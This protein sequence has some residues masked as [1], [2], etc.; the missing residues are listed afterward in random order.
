[1]RI[2]HAL[3]LFVLVFL[4]GALHGETMQN[5]LAQ[6]R[7]G[8]E[9]VFDFHQ[10]ITVVGVTTTSEHTVQLRVTTATKDLLSREN[11]TTWLQW[12]RQGAPGALSDDTITLKTDR[13]AVVHGVNTQHVQWL[14]TLL[15]LELT[16]IPDSKRRRAGPPPSSE[17]IDLRPLFQP[18]IV[19]HGKPIETKTDAYSTQMPDDGTELASRTLI[20]YFPQSQS[21]VQPFPYWIES[22]SSSYH[23]SVID[24]ASSIP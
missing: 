16:K 1:M 7:P 13:A 8:D 24:S 23:V 21:A 22:P 4:C 9:V 2:V 19:V 10:S 5:R 20:L 18:R 6:L 14:L 17:E 3:K 15:Q 12:F 11:F